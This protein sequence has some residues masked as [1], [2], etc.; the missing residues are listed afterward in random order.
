MQVQ[1]FNKRLNFLFK[2]GTSRG[3]YT[4]RDIVI[5]KISS[6]NFSAYGE[7][8]PLPRLSIDDVDNYQELIAKAV[9]EFKENGKLD[10]DKYRSLPSIYFAFESALMHLNKKSLKLFD[11]PFT[12]C[13]EGIKIN[14]LVWMGDYELMRQRLIE[15]IEKGFECIKIKIGAIDLEDE[16]SLLSKIRREFSDRDIQIRLDANGAFKAD[17]ALEILKRLSEFNI[18]S[19]EQPI[20]AGQIDSMAKL[21]EKSPIDL[22]LDEELIR[23]VTKEQKQKLLEWIKPKYIILKPS[24]HGGIKGSLEWIDIAKK[25]NI[26]YWI[27]SALESNIGLNVIAQFASSLNINIPQGLGTGQLFDNNIDYPL[28]IQK[29]KLYFDKQKINEVDFKSFAI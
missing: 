11:T 7:A 22:A 16:I 6:D 2:A 18:H 9:V 25:L 27:T 10:F 8:A 12:N 20:A 1:T 4:T 21:V 26:G 17:N 13:N 15:K 5:V 3:Y 14:G 24:L 19:L 23:V 29:D 28:Y